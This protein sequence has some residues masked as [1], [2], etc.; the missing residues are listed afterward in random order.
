MTRRRRRPTRSP[1]ALLV[2][3]LGV[4][5]CAPA[6][7]VDVEES[8]AIDGALVPDRPAGVPDATGPAPTVDD[9]D[10]AAQRPAGTLDWAGCDEFGIPAWVTAATSR[11]EC[12]RLTV[13]M[14]PGGGS[15]AQSDVELALTRHPATGNRRGTILVNPGG[16]GGAGLPVAWGIRPGLPTDMLRG[17]DIVSW[18]PRGVGRSTPAI[19]CGDAESTE[20]GFIATCVAETGDLS[21]YLSAP[22]S[23]ADMEA[24]RVALGEDELDF[25]GF[26]YGS[27]LGAHYAARHPASTGAF[28]LDGPTDPRAG[29]SDGPFENGFPVL[30]TDGRPAARARL[31]ELCDATDRCLSGRVATDVLDELADSVDELPTDDHAGAPEVVERR[32][33]ERFLDASLTSAADWELL[34]TALGDADAGDGSALAAMIAIE[35]FVDD[36]DRDDDGENEDPADETDGRA[37]RF[38]NFVE[39]NFMIYCAD[40][41][42]LVGAPGFCADMPVNEDVFEPIGPVDVDT[43]IL[44]IG[45]VDDPLTPGANA[46][47]FVAA[48]SD[49]THIVWEGVGHTAFPGWTSCIDGAVANQFLERVRP[50]DGTR[51]T[52]LEGVTDDAELA[53]IL[54]GFE[55]NEAADWLTNALDP[56]RTDGAEP[57]CVAGAVADRF[58]ES[59]A[60]DRLVAHVV[61]DVTSD[62]ALEALG[63]AIARC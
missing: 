32:A 30:S 59:T 36:L 23:V 55:R 53:E 42:P 6:P 40:F 41:G 24:I 15:P 37:D 46:P 38:D 9:G 31:A 47:E 20:P 8:A 43:P 25:L 57:V 11:W 28:V 13:A 7:G 21:S 4:V 62:A 50:P 26:S 54:F 39:A 1:L 52:M 34:A 49:A 17:F 14:D 3:A 29:A 35:E 22:Y 19:S 51:C 5:A 33:Y 63:T 61:L 10:D 16:P 27:I 18:D 45:T 60:G 48:L 44:V 2:A 56:S 12:A 58:D